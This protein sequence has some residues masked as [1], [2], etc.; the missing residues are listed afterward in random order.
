MGCPGCVVGR[1]PNLLQQKADF[2][3]VFADSFCQHLLGPPSVWSLSVRDAISIGCRLYIGAV[4]FSVIPPPGVKHLFPFPITKDISLYLLGQSRFGSPITSSL[5]RGRDRMRVPDPYI[6]ST[7][8]ANF[9]F[10]FSYALPSCYS[11]NLLSNGLLASSM[12]GHTQVCIFFF[13]IV[14][15]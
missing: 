5:M 14:S 12:K 9:C 8:L 13:S 1:L 2:Q 6:P 10:P 3:R 11:R 4:F 7:S 15:S